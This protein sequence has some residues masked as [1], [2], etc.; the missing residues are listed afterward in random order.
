MLRSPESISIEITESWAIC[1]EASGK[2]ADTIRAYRSHLRRFGAWLAQPPRGKAVLEAARMD[3]SGY[4]VDHARRQL[5]GT[6]RRVAYQALKAFFSWAASEG[7]IPGI[8]MTGL[9][10][11]PLDATPSSNET[12]DL[13]QLRRL[14]HAANP[15]DFWGLRD[16]ALLHLLWESGARRSEVSKILVRDLDMATGRLLL[17][18]IKREAPRYV[19][20]GPA[21]LGWVAQWLEKRKEFGVESEYL[22]ISAHFRQPGDRQL[23]AHQVS[24]IVRGYAKKC[25]L[26]QITYPSGKTRGSVHAHSLR[27][28]C[29]TEAYRNTNNLV[30]VSRMLGHKAVSVTMRYLQES[31]ADQ[32]EI[33]A[34][35]AVVW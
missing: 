33:A 25:G 9:K 22:F 15:G 20:I 6:Y 13:A 12:M 35:R 19:R 17:R 21:A 1:L 7:M 27:H 30:G 28:L 18:S 4:M 29:A 10:L 34:T 11:P 8:P 5:S 23:C 3:V 2:S 26:P 24:C 31:E 16:R 32:A 14:L